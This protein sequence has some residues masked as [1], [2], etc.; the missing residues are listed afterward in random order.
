MPNSYNRAPLLPHRALRFPS[1]LPSPFC[2]SEY[3]PQSLFCLDRPRVV[4]MKGNPTWSAS[5]SSLIDLRRPL[6]SPRRHDPLPFFVLFFSKPLS[7]GAATALPAVLL[8]EFGFLRSESYN[9][10][11][12]SPPGVWP[13]TP[14]SWSPPFESFCYLDRSSNSP[15]ILLLEKDVEVS[16]GRAIPLLSPGRSLDSSSLVLAF[17]RS[18]SFTSRLSPAY[19]LFPNSSL[20]ILFPSGQPCFFLISA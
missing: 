15:N 1:L 6:F 17:S 19:E 8:A 2:C 13:H 3:P 10:F 11:L 4:C 16:R 20:P 14:T 18:S 12:D 7:L 9:R 5:I